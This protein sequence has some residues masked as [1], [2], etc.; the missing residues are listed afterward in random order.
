MDRKVRSV[1]TGSGEP[2]RTF[3]CPSMAVPEVHYKPPTEASPPYPITR[4]IPAVH[5]TPAQAGRFLLGV[6]KRR[7]PGRE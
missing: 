2:R 5:R 3:L 7:W 1:D 4:S 6:I